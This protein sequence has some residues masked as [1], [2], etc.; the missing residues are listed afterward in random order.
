M[1]HRGV[2]RMPMSRNRLMAPCT[3]MAAATS[4]QWPS[5]NGVHVFSRGVHW[6]VKVNMAEV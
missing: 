6:K 2:I 4:M 5:R 1:A 3:T